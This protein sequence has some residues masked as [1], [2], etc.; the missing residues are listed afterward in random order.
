MFRVLMIFQFNFG[1]F[2]KVL[3]LKYDFIFE[4]KKNILLSLLRQ[5]L[6]Y[7]GLLKLSMIH[8]FFN[9]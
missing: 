2:E 4:N 3:I 6:L 8:N 1:I 5:K 9:Y 7:H